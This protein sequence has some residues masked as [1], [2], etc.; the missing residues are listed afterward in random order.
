M[1]RVSIPLSRYL[2]DLLPESDLSPRELGLLRQLRS[3]NSALLADSLLRELL[4]SLL[5]RGVLAV[6]SRVTE[7]DEELLT[8]R[9]PARRLRFSFRLPLPSLGPK[10]RR[11]PLPLDPPSNTG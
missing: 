11:L 8:L 9:D 10:L 7:R 3:A 5:T 2:Q 4:E 6:L 1:K